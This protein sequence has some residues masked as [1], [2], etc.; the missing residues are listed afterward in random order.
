M[1]SAVRRSFEPLP[2]ATIKS[3]CVATLRKQAGANKPLGP[4]V[5]GA[6]DRLRHRSGDLALLAS[7]LLEV[8]VEWLAAWSSSQAISLDDAAKQVVQTFKEAERRLTATPIPEALPNLELLPEAALPM[9]LPAA[10]N[11][12]ETGENEACE[13]RVKRLR[14]SHTGPSQLLRRA[15]SAVAASS[16][17]ICTAAA[18]N[19]GKSFAN[20]CDTKFSSFDS[21]P[22]RQENKAPC[23]HALVISCGMSLERILQAA[24][25]NCIP[26]LGIA[27]TVPL[28]RCSRNC[29]A[30]GQ[31]VQGTSLRVYIASS[32][33]RARSVLKPLLDGRLR[34]PGFHSPGFPVYVEPSCPQRA[35]WLNPNS[36]PWYR[37][38][39]SENRMVE[40]LYNTDLLAFT[41]AEAVLIMNAW[42]PYLRA[43]GAHLSDFFQDARARFF[44]TPCRSQATED[45]AGPLSELPASLVIIFTYCGFEGVVWAGVIADLRRLRDKEEILSGRPTR[46]KKKDLPRNHQ[47][48]AEEDLAED[49][50]AYRVGTQKEDL[51]EATLLIL[52]RKK[53]DLPEGH[54][55]HYPANKRRT[56]PEGYF[57]YPGDKKG[58]PCD[59][60]DLADREG[61]P[62]GGPVPIVGTK[63]EDLLEGQITEDLP[64]G[65][66]VY[67]DLLDGQFA[68][69]GDKTS[70][71]CRKATSLLMTKKEDLPEGQ[72]P[73]PGD[74][75]GGQFAY[76]KNKELGPGTKKEDLLEGQIAYPG[77]K[78]AKKEE[79]LLEGEFVDLWGQ[80]IQEDL[81]E[82]EKNE[83][84]LEGQFAYPGD[85]EGDLP[86]GEFTYPG[87]KGNNTLV[88][89]G[90]EYKSEF[91]AYPV[92]DGPRTV[93]I[94]R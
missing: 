24:G 16:T 2:W 72:F 77:D 1:A 6:A 5:A 64:E 12:A 30:T 59:G 88:G 48:D 70:G 45:E 78:E 44:Y 53:E 57:A 62:G 85:K 84:L 51:P 7:R 14:L 61:G 43:E 58:R 50:F 38:L 81:L 46:T 55:A 13:P 17:Q 47:A 73:H 79:D 82:D 91:K 67:E 10:P 71:T 31:G 21:H 34:L 93:V 75:E 33:Y 42:S 9:E 28:L 65:H 29:L 63:N 18:Y 37:R 8:D 49:H 74:K 60:A 15:A 89:Y 22:A 27:G 41:P 83:D 23:L 25:S 94:R 86:E 20:C 4:P 76:P 80:R 92:K 36:H 69:P 68:Y 87:D 32:L 26:L 90:L 3:D 39:G 11:A 66:F 40:W 35:F 52:G 56:L 54:F 19:K